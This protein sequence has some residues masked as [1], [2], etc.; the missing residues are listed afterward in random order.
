M[1][2]CS[3]L[4]VR[5]VDTLRSEVIMDGMQNIILVDD[6][7][8]VPELKTNMLSVSRLHKKGCRT[9]FADEPCKPE[10]GMVSTIDKTTGCT[11]LRE[12]ER[13]FG[14]HKF[15]LRSPGKSHTVKPQ[16]LLST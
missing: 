14:L 13:E 12:I 5:N 1:G 4:T 9:T 10:V 7:A 11:I 6:V 16:V 3:Q 2:E 15:I 8:F